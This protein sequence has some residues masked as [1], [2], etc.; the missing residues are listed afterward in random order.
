MYQKNYLPYLKPNMKPRIIIGVITAIVLIGGFLFYLNTW[1]PM[2]PGVETYKI[3]KEINV[4][5]KG[6]SESNPE[7]TEARGER[8]LILEVRNEPGFIVSIALPPQGETPKTHPFLSGM[9]YD[10]VE[11]DAIGK[12]LEK[13]KTFEEFIALL[14]NSGYIVEKVSGALDQSGNTT[15]LS[16]EDYIKGNT[17]I[18]SEIQKN[19]TTSTTTLGDYKCLSKISVKRGGDNATNIKDSGLK[20]DILESFSDG[21]FSGKISNYN[22]DSRNKFYILMNQLMIEE[23]VPTH[24][25]LSAD[26]CLYDEDLYNPPYGATLNYYVEHEYCTNKCQTGT[27]LLRVDLKE[28]GSFVGYRTEFKW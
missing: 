3:Y 24:K 16:G 8:K 17:N 12:L 11:E 19:A 18:G 4:V 27:Y 10:P 5:T 13:A 20:T 7:L 22:T 15:N 9:S 21:A 14:Q 25:H 2:Q 23:K 26:V 6:F 28:N 1:T